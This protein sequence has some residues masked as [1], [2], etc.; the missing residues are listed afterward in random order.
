MDD[1]N[2]N[3]LA[4]A[5]IG[6]AV[7]EL[8]IRHYLLQKGMY[9]VNVLQKESTNYV[10][11]E[12]QAKILDNLINN[13]YLNDEELSIIKRARN[14]KIKSKPKH[15]SIVTYKK[16]TALEALFGYLY[17]KELNGRINDIMT[18]IL[19]GD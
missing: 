19:E 13:N 16:A 6:D 5:Y 12:S 3:S 10:S 9:D 8:K 14:H 11:A 2:I 15:A 7:Y 4:L 17:L 1:I 18:L